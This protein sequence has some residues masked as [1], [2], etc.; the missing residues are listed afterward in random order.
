MSIFSKLFTI[1]HLVDDLWCT[2]VFEHKNKEYGAFILRKNYLK[3]LM[4]GLVSSIL[5]VLFI[6]YIPEL[7]RWLSFSNTEYVDLDSNETEL[8]TE[9]SL[10]NIAA[11]QIKKTESPKNDVLVPTKATKSQTPKIVKEETQ[12]EAQTK[13]DPNEDANTPSKTE[14]SGD[15]NLNQ[16]GSNTSQASTG[17]M[18]AEVMPKF[19]GGDKA[20]QQYLNNNIK[21]PSIA[22]Q[23]GVEGIVLIGFV[24]DENGYLKN[25]K[26]LKSLHPAC[27]EE[28][29]R[30]VRYM[31]EWIP[32]K[33]HGKNV[34]VQFRLPIQFKLR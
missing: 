21:F 1:H 23:T 18:F 32:G 6:V 14:S 33:H 26:I 11:T 29:M 25:P 31:P 9:Y 3:H 10:P 7:K 30:V 24:I 20:L 34:S 17:F 4:I 8:M 12:I 16:Q 19:P 15:N 27:D 2:L 28:A 5:L 22:A 13:H